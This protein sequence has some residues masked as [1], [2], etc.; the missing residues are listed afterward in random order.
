M[1]GAFG[2]SPVAEAMLT[3]A[4]RSA[5]FR[6]AMAHSAVLKLP[7][8]FTSITFCQ[9]SKAK[10]SVGPTGMIPAAFTSPS[11]PPS[12]AAAASSADATA[13]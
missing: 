10:S 2:K 11:I 5:R 9:A 8:R 3:M 1:P 6:E 13:A 7:V 4:G 12:F